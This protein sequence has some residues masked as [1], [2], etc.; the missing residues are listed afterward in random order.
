MNFLIK[1]GFIL[2]YSTLFFSPVI[3]QNISDLELIRAQ[4]FANPSYESK[5]VVNFGISDN[6]HFI[7]KYNPVSITLSALL[8]AYQKY[9]SQQISA[10]CL[11][12]PSCSEYSKLL[13]KRYGIFG[14]IITSADRLMR[15]DRISATTIN[16][17]SINEYDGKVHESVER[18]KIKRWC[19]SWR[20]VLLFLF[21]SFY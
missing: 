10:D 15:C 8:F 1:T 2:A 6:Q 7:V 9:L 4:N 11:F 18:Y 3:C 12:V 20:I 16:P 14:G 19:F 5:R 17:I 13:F 21:P